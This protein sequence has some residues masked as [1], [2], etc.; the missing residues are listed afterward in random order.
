MPCV[1]LQYLYGWLS[2]CMICNRSVCT[3]DTGYSG[4]QLMQEEWRENMRDHR[5]VGDTSVKLICVVH[6]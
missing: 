6:A 4:L 2:Y 1:V 3:F 5:A